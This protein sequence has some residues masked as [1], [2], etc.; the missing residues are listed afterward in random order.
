MIGGKG[1]IRILLSLAVGIGASAAG[2]S[3]SSVPLGVA[4]PPRADATFEEQFRSS[5]GL[6]IE[7][8]YLEQLYDQARVH[9]YIEA[10]NPKTPP[11]DLPPDAIVLAPGDLLMTVQEY[12]RVFA[13]MADTDSIHAAM[14]FLLDSPTFGG[15]ALDEAGRHLLIRTTDGVT[16]PGLTLDLST[17]V[18]EVQKGSVSLNQARKLS[19]RIGTLS[20]KGVEAADAIFALSYDVLRDSIH[21]E[22]DDASA[23]RGDVQPLVEAAASELGLSARVEVVYGPRPQAASANTSLNPRTHGGALIIANLVCTQSFHGYV[24]STV[25]GATAAHCGLESA[26]VWHGGIGGDVGGMGPWNPKE[27]WSKSSWTKYYNQL[28]TAPHQTWIN[29]GKSGNWAWSDV[30]LLD[31]WSP[32]SFS[33]RVYDPTHGL[34][35]VR[36]TVIPLQNEWAMTYGA[37]SNPL[38]QRIVQVQQVH[39]TLD[40]DINKPGTYY[41]GGNQCLRARIYDT[42][43]TGPWGSSPQIIGGDSGGPVTKTVWRDVGGVIVAVALPTGVISTTTASGQAWHSY[44]WNVN[45][46]LGFNPMQG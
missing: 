31:Y 2:A 9:G 45:N 30:A 15:A 7:R 24:S 34:I 42:F 12:E 22:A 6:S 27:V 8:R 33:G 21:V 46:A 11:K 35:R 38:T 41:A 43:V 4:S 20:A 18:L 39:Q 26:G 10:F 25:Y 36:E 40:I 23:A 13:V 5:Y 3:A 16:P 28:C 14:P 37:N 17:V 1:C 32:T 44:M 19:D 29:T